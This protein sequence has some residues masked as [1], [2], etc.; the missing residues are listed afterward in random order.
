MTCVSPEGRI[1][2]R[3]YRTL[4]PEHEAAWKRIVDF[5]H[6][7]TDAKI[8]IQLG[9]SGAKGSTQLGW[10]TMDAPLPS[11]NWTVMA[12]S[13]VAWSAREPDAPSD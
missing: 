3:L 5:V 11:G 7:E 10:E 6:A 12:P 8:A 2:T 9:H 13:A 4:S 1:T